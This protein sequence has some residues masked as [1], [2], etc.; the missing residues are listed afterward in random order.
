MNLLM[1]FFFLL[2]FTLVEENLEKETQPKI[3]K[4]AASKRNRRRKEER[5]CVMSEMGSSCS[6]RYCKSENW[7]ET[8]LLASCGILFLS[9]L[10]LHQAV[11][12][13]FCSVS[14]FCLEYV[15]LLCCCSSLSFRE[16][17]GLF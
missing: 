7:E 10:L 14:C 9:L 12:V 1:L 13:L 4:T 17:M 5:V 15:L 16:K 3:K 6:S 11:F 2:L 8:H